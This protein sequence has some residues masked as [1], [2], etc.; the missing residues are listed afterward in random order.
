MTPLTPPMSSSR[1]PI[2]VVITPSHRVLF[3]DFFLP[4]LDQEQFNLQ[5]LELDQT[6]AGEFLADD[7]KRCILFKVEQIIASIRRHEG[8]IIVWSD[9]DIQFFAMKA[10]DILAPFRD[11]SLQFAAQRLNKKSDVVC[12][13][14]YAIRCCRETADFFEAVLD[15]TVHKTQGNE[16]DAINLLLRSP[17]A[18]HWQLLGSQFYARSHGALLPPNLVLHHATCILPGDAVRQKIKLLSELENHHR[19]SLL[20]HIL[21]QC[22]V[23][24]KSLLRACGLRVI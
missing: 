10:D 3:N 23:L 20:R 24:A 2:Y 5:S 7:F 19:W 21:F 16:Q 1:V 11:A 14:F 18:L 17:G 9:I 13:G 4:S 15:A 22:K 6:G 12:G 8:Q